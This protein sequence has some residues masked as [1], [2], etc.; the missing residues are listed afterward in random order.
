MALHDAEEGSWHLRVCV[1]GISIGVQL[2]QPG[3]SS[4]SGSCSRAKL[5]LSKRSQLSTS[6]QTS[7]PRMH[8]P[9]QTAGKDTCMSASAQLRRYDW[10]ADDEPILGC[11]KNAVTCHLKLLFPGACAET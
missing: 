3:W 2:G 11:P 10:F 8:V 4:G 9:P 7:S 1:L 5:V 6:L